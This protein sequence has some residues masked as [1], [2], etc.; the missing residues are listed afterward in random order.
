[1]TEFV[2]GPTLREAFQDDERA[3]KALAPFLALL[4]RNGVFHGDLHP[5]NM[6]WSGSEWVLIDLDALRHPLRRMFR[7]RLILEQWAQLAFRL[8]AVP[9]LESSFREYSVLAEFPGDPSETWADV[10]RRA[11]RI[12]SARSA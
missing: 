10:V 11:E 9:E 3:R 2:A 7:R 4:H 1:V 12:R 6:I 8:G 5:A